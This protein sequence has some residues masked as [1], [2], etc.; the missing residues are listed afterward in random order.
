VSTFTR[1]LAS[2]CEVIWAVM[3]RET[4]TRFGANSFG[5]LWAIIE[6]LM[7]IMTFWILLV[8]VGRDAPYGMDQYTFIASGIV[9]Y[10]LF[11]TTANRVAES[12]NGNRPL[13]Y[14]PHVQP[15]DLVFA[16][17]ILELATYGG[18]FIILLGGHALYHQSF[19]IDSAL[20]T[21]VGLVISGML[22]MSL[23][24]VFC[25]LGQYSKFVD[26][27]RGFFFRP[28][29][30]IS[31]I[32]FTLNDLPEEGRAVILFNPVVH[33]VEMVRDGWFATYSARHIDISYPLYFILALGFIGLSLE[34]AVRTRIQ[35]T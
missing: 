15:L 18:V 33:C 13:L 32:F 14:Y 6:P 3:L 19:S 12:I 22:G 31:G 16:R 24:M 26:R 30:W 28:F 25:M 2:Q 8:I 10:T 11:A 9:P 23:G 4:R 5:Y 34:R 20:V 27:F 29:F 1:G 35:V 21:C 7:M 17:A